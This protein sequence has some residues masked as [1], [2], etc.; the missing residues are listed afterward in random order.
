MRS[1]RTTHTE[2]RFDTGE[3]FTETH[4]DTW[5][6]WVNMVRRVEDRMGCQMRSVGDSGHRWSFDGQTCTTQ[7]V[8]SF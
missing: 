4:R 8:M 7:T 1:N 2:F 5:G 3:V 6:G